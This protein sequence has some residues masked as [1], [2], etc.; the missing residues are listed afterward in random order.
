MCVPRPPVRCAPA[1]DVLK[2]V[3]L[4]VCEFVCARVFPEQST[5]G[6]VVPGSGG[7]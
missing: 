7:Y 1:A 2:G 5:K 4:C 6:C 3:T